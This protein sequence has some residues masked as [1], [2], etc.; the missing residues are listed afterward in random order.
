MYITMTV[1]ITKDRYSYKKDDGVEKEI[2]FE[3]P[4]IEA[5]EKLI[6][7]LAKSMKS[8]AVNARLQYLTKMMSTT[9]PQDGDE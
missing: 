3:I 9:D 4:D 7:S 1:T 6:K 5:N 2:S 8:M